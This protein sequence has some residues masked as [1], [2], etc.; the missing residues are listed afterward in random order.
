MQQRH[1]YDGSGGTN[2][3]GG[4]G[5]AAGG[6][7]LHGSPTLPAASA[8]PPISTQG[9]LHAHQNFLQM[10]VSAGE[11]QDGYRIVIPQ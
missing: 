5:G 6:G 9:G 8:L 1:S 3:P 10:S 7:G 11:R 4:S 2:A